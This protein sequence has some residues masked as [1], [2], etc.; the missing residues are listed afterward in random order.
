MPIFKV[1]FTDNTIYEGGNSVYNSLWDQIPDKEIACLEYFLSNGS[2][3]VLERFEKYGHVIEATKNVYGPPGTDLK[4]K[5]HNIYVM[6]LKNGIVKSFR[7]AL[8]GNSGNDKYHQGD[9]TQRD[10]PLGEEFRGRPISSW[11]NGIKEVK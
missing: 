8:I 1:T 3:L 5:L 2:K 7:I 10:I 6:G 4:P 9:I 11:K